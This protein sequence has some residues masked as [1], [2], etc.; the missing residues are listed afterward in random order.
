MTSSVAPRQSTVRVLVVDDHP[1]FCEGVGAW[2]ARQEGMVFC[3][4][5]DTPASAMTAMF[6][7]RP[8]VVLLDLHLKDGDGY[9]VLRR[10]MHDGLPTKVI[11]VSRKDGFDCAERALGAGARGYVLKDEACETLLT[12]IRTVVGGGVHLS[13]SLHRAR[14]RR[15]GSEGESPVER[16]RSLSQR[17]LQVMRLL[18]RGRATKQ[19]ASDLGISPKTVEFYRESLKGKLRLPDSLMLVRV[20]TIWEYEGRFDPWVAREGGT[21][22]PSVP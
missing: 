14:V 22:M 19:I 12:A 13:P 17:E 5:A 4:Q 11:V 8:D 7:H 6:T 2:I 20:A 21:S 18:G 3:G 15:P 10:V 9:D 16:I 1:F